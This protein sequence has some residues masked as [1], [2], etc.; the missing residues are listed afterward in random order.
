MMPPPPPSRPASP[1]TDAD[2]SA[3]AGFRRDVAA[4]ACSQV[5]VGVRDLLFVAAIA[6]TLG[7]EVY[8]VWSQVMITVA[9]LDP[10]VRLRLDMAVVRYLAARSLRDAAGEVH[11]MALLIGGV[12]AVIA[13]LLVS[14][15]GGASTLIFGSSAHAG[16]LLALAVLLVSRALFSF[17]GGVY[18]A[19]GGIAFF[20][21]VRAIQ[22][23]SE[24][25]AVTL[26]AVGLRA[27]LQP[28]LWTAVA[29]QCLFTLLLAVDVGRRSG[30]VRPRFGRLLRALRYSLPLIPNAMLLWAIGY[31]DRYVITHL[32]GLHEVARYSAAYRMAQL[33]TF[34]V[35][36][37]SFALFPLISRMWGRE[38]DRH[39]ADRVAR[40]LRG[41][42][43]LS[44]PM[45]LGVAAVGDR[46]LMYLS[47]AEVLASPLLLLQLAV[48]G[49]LL[50]MYQ[51]YVYIVHLSERTGW[52]VVTFASVAGTNLG[53]NLLLVPHWGLLGAAAATLLAYLMQFV[54]VLALSRR[55]LRVRF[56]WRSLAAASVSAL[57]MAAAARAMSR[58][59]LA[60]LLGAIAVSVVIYGLCL[61]AL[62][63]IRPGDVKRLLRLSGGRRR[64]RG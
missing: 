55:T 47:G 15:R 50:G 10:V 6:S 52:L 59:S 27:G 30:T 23:A 1:A 53:L 32:L 42:L 58:A 60:G 14:G 49:L 34:F 40:A 13:V 24:L 48:A 41:L 2:P 54:V 62:R 46:L 16:T 22:V 20:S 37:I 43:L 11:A 33:V 9:L 61:V 12:G 21:A 31:A 57:G 18:R 17:L 28:T 19:F 38:P 4:Y 45:A 64:D 44:V 51:I 8:G 36:P 35:M 39:V 5:A 29:V 3:K 56:P 7:A 25:G 63:E 26:V